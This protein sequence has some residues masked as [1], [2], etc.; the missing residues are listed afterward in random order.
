VECRNVGSRV[1]NDCAKK[2]PYSRTTS[3]IVVAM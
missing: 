2:S 3:M 1:V